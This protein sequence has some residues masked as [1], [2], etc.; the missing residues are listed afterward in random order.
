MRRREF[1][2]R[3][4]GVGVAGGLQVAGLGAPENQPTTPPGAALLTVQADT[5]LMDILSRIDQFTP[6]TLHLDPRDQALA[7]AYTLPPHW[8]GTAL[9]C[10]QA[11]PALNRL[12]GRGWEGSRLAADLREEA[13]S[14]YQLARTP[15]VNGL[16]TPA[17]RH[18]ACNNPMWFWRWDKSTAVSTPVE[19]EEKAG[20]DD[21]GVITVFQRVKEDGDVVDTQPF[22]IPALVDDLTLQTVL[23]WIK[24]RGGVYVNLDG[25]PFAPVHDPEQESERSGPLLAPLRLV[26]VRHLFGRR[27]DAANR[28]GQWLHMFAAGMSVHTRELGGDWRWSAYRVSARRVIYTLRD[29]A[30]LQK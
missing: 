8:H 23:D 7:Q 27:L 6:A 11:A 20:S 14:N 4:I 21:G 22:K 18:W 25:Y 30:H 24:Q 12:F 19:G 17:S 5:T 13:G 16:L 29:Y 15:F 3:V 28:L 1:L 10:E 2:H 9:N 26:T